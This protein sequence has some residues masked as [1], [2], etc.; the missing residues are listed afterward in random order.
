MTWTRSFQ[1]VVVHWNIFNIDLSSLG[2]HGS[3]PN[4][5]SNPY[6]WAVLRNPLCFF[7]FNLRCQIGMLSEGCLVVPLSFQQQK[8]LWVTRG[9]LRKDAARPQIFQNSTILQKRF[10]GK[11]W[12]RKSASE[13]QTQVSVRQ[14]KIPTE[15]KRPRGESPIKLPD[16]GGK[17]SWGSNSSL[18][19]HH[20]ERQIRVFNSTD[21]VNVSIYIYPHAVSNI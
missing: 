3:H 4:K 20:P 19:H 10:G 5:K 6:G 12:Y 11:M 9:C 15:P 2:N 21:D 13:K 16:L 14:W 18:R 8:P 1:L 17:K 7:A